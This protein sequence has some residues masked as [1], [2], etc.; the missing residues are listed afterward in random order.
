[1][2][3]NKFVKFTAIFLAILMLASVFAVLMNV[4]VIR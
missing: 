2:G 3:R 1:M 4:F